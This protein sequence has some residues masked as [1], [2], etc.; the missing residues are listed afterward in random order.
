[1]KWCAKRSS[2]VVSMSSFNLLTPSR[3]LAVANKADFKRGGKGVVVGEIE[4]SD[5]PLPINNEMK[6]AA[7]SNDCGSRRRRNESGAGQLSVMTLGQRAP[8]R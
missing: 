4:S 5:K 6:D 8:G 3:R 2:G 7:K 1:M